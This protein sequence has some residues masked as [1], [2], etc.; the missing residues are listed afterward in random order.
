MTILRPYENTYLWKNAFGSLAPEDDASAHLADEYAGAWARACE[1]S[2]RIAR[3][4]QG[5]TLHDDR[6]FSALW[7]CADIVA[8]EKYQLSPIELFVFGVAVLIHDAAHTVL[9]Y[10]GGIDAICETPEW[11][12][13]Q[14]AY[15]G[16][17]EDKAATPLAD[18]SPEIRN[19]LL[20]NT[21][22]ALHAKQASHMLSQAF[23]HPALGAD[24]Y[25]IADPTIRTHFGTLIG[26]I[27]ASH[28]WDI[29]RLEKLGRQS[30]PIFPYNNH[31]IIR[32]TVLGGLLRVADAVQIDATRA[33]DFEYALTKPEGDSN[34]HWLAQNRISIAPDVHDPT[35]LLITSSVRFTVSEAG[36]WWKAYELATLADRE[37][38]ATDQLLRDISMPIFKVSRVRG[39]SSPASFSEHVKT[40]AWVPVSAEVRISDT[41][42]IVEMFGGRHL[43]GDDE[44]VPLRELIQNGVDA[45]RA[46]RTLEEGFTGKIKISLRS[47]TNMKGEKGHYLR[48]ADN[49]IGMSTAV[50]TGPFLAFG[51]SGWVSRVLREERPGFVGKRARHVGRYGIGF[52]SV[53]MISDEVE[54]TSRPFDLSASHAKVL[55]FGGGLKLRPIIK[56]A[57]DTLGMEVSTSVELFITDETKNKILHKS[58]DTR[59]FKNGKSYIE[60]ASDYTLAE[61]AGVLCP[62]IDVDLVVQNCQ[63]EV[64]HL[65]GA[66]WDSEDAEEWL[67]RITGSKAE[68]IPDIVRRNYDLLENIVL[69]GGEIIGRATLNPTN[70]KLRSHAIGGLGKKE[71]AGIEE[72]GRHFVGCIFNSPRGPRR[73]LGDLVSVKS[74]ARWAT[75]QVQRWQSVSTTGEQLNFVAANAAFYGADPM[76]IANGLVDDTWLTVPEVFEKLAAAE[77]IYAPVEPVAYHRKP[78]QWK[79]MASVNFFS[80]H[81]LYQDDVKVTLPN[82]LL[83]RPTGDVHAYWCLPEEQDEAPHSFLGCLG[84]YALTKN[85]CLSMEGDDIEFGYYD[86]D[87]F[88]RMGIKKGQRVKFPGIRLSATRG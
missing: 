81:L 15:F 13:E 23:K 60:P 57:P 17:A 28:H 63:G 4:A 35:A 86:G 65:V 53:F 37:L 44:T 50:L 40:S 1:L 80:G 69:D 41:N 59:V 30:N 7:Q 14:T 72:G 22:R 10:S 20:F 77:V 43:Y 34:D 54:V 84:R 51:D 70:V 85:F 27:A 16:D 32:P 26:E 19:I 67:L 33:P 88:A 21:L 73:D 83:S 78:T 66:A 82:V 45:V 47:D 49:G 8:G 24:F 76:P 61:L 11:K 12:D 3:D 31:G 87:D 52:F 38:R 68:D 56:D 36:A 64:E 2:T 62:A 75:N 29:S 39:V 55:S 74:V 71:R 25:L 6:H 46:R 42:K 5:L 58:N 18:L 9:A 79:I 48:V